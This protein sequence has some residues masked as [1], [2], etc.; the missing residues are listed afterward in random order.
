MYS[1]PSISSLRTSEVHSWS[2]SA[3]LPE[4]HGTSEHSHSHLT[5]HYE[6]QNI[7][8]THLEIQLLNL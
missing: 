6:L 1:K 3:A 5:N 8:L 7:T 4:A 2:S